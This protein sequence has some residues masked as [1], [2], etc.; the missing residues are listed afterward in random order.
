[1]ISTGGN[2]AHEASFASATATGT[3]VFFHTTE[4]L[5]PQDDTPS[6]FDVYDRSGGNTTLVTPG[7]GA[8][9]L[10]G[11]SKDGERVFFHTYHPLVDADTDIWNDVYERY[12]GTTTLISTGPASTSGANIAWMYGSSD[13]GT[14]VFFDTDE[15]LTSGDTDASVDVYSAS[16]VLTGYPRPKGASP[17][18]VSLVPAYARCTSP[19]RVHGP[20][21]AHPSCNPPAQVSPML[22]VGSPDANGVPA[23]S[24]ARLRLIVSPGAPGPPD[25]SNVDV[26]ISAS[27]VRCRVTNAAC[28]GGSNS[29]FTGNLLFTWSVSLTDKLNGSPAVESATVADF[30][31]QMPVAC[32][33]TADTTIG[34]N[35]AVN[36]TLNAVVP[37]AVLDGKRAMWALDTVEAHDPGPNGTGYGSG[38]PGTCG[39]GDESVF[40]RPGI[41]IP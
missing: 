15:R 31:L 18:S 35:C 13:D 33:A 10:Q 27:D 37:G 34:G 23:N 20:S 19:N 3:H 25:D 16:Q 24:I 5:S 2:G 12:G 14:K 6:T 26:A 29:D 41:F 1:L 28:P 30:P 21:L 4:S 22:T 38:C 9:F 39:D 7:D 17:F 8:A 32:A 36:T 11:I 40:L